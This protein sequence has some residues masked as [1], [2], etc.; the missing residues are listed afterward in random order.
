[1]D[2]TIIFSKGGIIYDRT[3]VLLR[4]NNKRN[5]I[6]YEKWSL[7]NQMIFCNNINILAF[8]I[9]FPKVNFFIKTFYIFPQT[10]LKGAF[11]WIYKAALT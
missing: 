9:N 2:R 10:V 11:Q 1:M 7:T 5:L 6:N 3:E 8:D 4:N